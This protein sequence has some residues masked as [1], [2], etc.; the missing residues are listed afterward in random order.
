MNRLKPSLAL[1]ALGLLCTCPRAA[2]AQEVRAWT[3]KA[4]GKQIE[5]S[6]VSADPK[7]RTVTIKNAGGQSFTLKVDRLADADL[8]YIKAHLNDA[9]GAP[10]PAPAPAPGAPP[11]A[12]APAPAAAAG[13]AKPPVGS[14]APPR[15]TIAVTPVKAFKRPQG[16]DILGKLKRVH[17]RLILNADG[18]TALKA[19]AESDPVSKDIL[20]KIGASVDQLMT[21]PELTKV[22]GTE[23]ASGAPGRQELYRLSHIGLLHYLKADPRCADRAMKEMMALSKDFTNWNPDKPDICSEF[24]WSMALGYD[25][26]RPN[27]T[28]DQAKTIRTAIIELGMEALMATLKGEPV[29]A[30][31][32]RAEAGSV[33]APPP[34]SAPKPPPAA[35]KK[36]DKD[37]PVSTEHMKAACALLLAAIAIADEE[38]NAAASAS[39]LAAK[40]FGKGMTQFA[41]DGIWVETIE[42]GDEVLDMAACVLTTFRSACGTDFGFSTIEGL[43]NAGVARMA[44]TGPAGIFNYG[45]ARSGNLNRNWVTSWL[46]LMYGNPGVPAVKVPGPTQAQG[47]SLLGLAG[48]LL[49]NSPAIDGYGTP[50][51]LDYAFNG[52]DVVTLRSAWNDSKALFVG[53][54]GGDNSLPD[55]QLDLGT[56]VLDAGGVRWGVDLGADSDRAIGKG[57]ANDPARFKLY[58]ESSKGQNVLY[59]GEDQA[60]NGKG[61]ITAFQSTPERGVGIV[62]LKGDAKVK[63]F[64]RGVMMVRNGTKPYVLMQDEIHIKTTASPVWTMHTR[65]EV[66]ADGSQATLKSGGAT[67][68]MNVLSPKGAKIIA[69]DPPDLKEPE[70]TLKGIKIIKIALD[71]VKGDQT[72]TVAFALGEAPTEAPVVPLAEWVKKK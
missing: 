56:F 69:A 21:L 11:A 20:T 41:P 33:K 29:P 54:K 24:V 32:K 61:N 14:P 66:K 43:P 52:A 13:G 28:N 15:P 44:L 36:E 60:T 25:W 62:D 45:D 1:A 22:Y 5:A 64:R 18:F 23:S 39:S 72:I 50:E 49:Y 6:M 57:K 47:A 7:A 65:A 26:F 48:L 17:P 38:P 37:E 51:A 12:P 70:G 19:R 35:K 30:I 42:K 40:V 63:G 68:T 67:L 3:D 16:S 58:R 34:K 31:S 71:G 9:P 53:L 8:A 4:S 59:F 2:D 55:A 46:A 27:L 10:T